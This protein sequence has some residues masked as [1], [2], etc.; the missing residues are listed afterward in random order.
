MNAHF[1]IPAFAP[2]TLVLAAAVAFA[3]GIPAGA[4]AQEV[5]CNASGRC[6]PADQQNPQGK[7]RKGFVLS[8]GLSASRL[9][10]SSPV[11][12][13]D[14]QGAFGTDLKIG[15]AFSNQFMLYYSNDANF[16]TFDAPFGD[17]TYLSSLGM[18]GIGGTYFLNPYAPSFYLHG[19]VGIGVLSSFLIDDPGNSDS[20]AG[21]GLS[22][23]GGYEFAR[24]FMVD[25][26]V[27]LTS[28]END[29]R[30]RALRVGLTWLLY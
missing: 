24:H 7:N 22:L 15:H 16:Y 11:G 12:S 14:S 20:I 13:G 5:V 4:H 29:L 9:H 21:L 26:E 8:L 6:T 2:S 27:I 18:T 25:G 10:F 19:T 28:L 23:G 1:R 3:P 30:G 17:G